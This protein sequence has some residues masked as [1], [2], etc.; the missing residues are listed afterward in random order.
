VIRRSEQKL[1]DV[2]DAMVEEAIAG[3]EV[4]WCS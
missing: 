2:I 1:A 4:I 3:E